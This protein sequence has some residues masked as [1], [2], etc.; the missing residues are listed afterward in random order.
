VHDQLLVGLL[1]LLGAQFF[2]QHLWN[3][4]TVYFQVMELIYMVELSY[5]MKKVVVAETVMAR[6]LGHVQRVCI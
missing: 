1:V 6:H 4:Y 5:N 3:I 2:L